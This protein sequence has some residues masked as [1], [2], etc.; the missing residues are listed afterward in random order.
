MKISSENI[1]SKVSELSKSISTYYKEN[2][3]DELCVVVPMNGGV[4]FAVDILREISNPGAD[5]I[6][7]SYVL[8]KDNE[9]IFSGS[10]PN[11]KSHILII[12]DIYDTGETLNELINYLDTEYNPVEIKT[13]VMLD[14]KIEKKSFVDIEWKGFDI[15]DT[16]VYGYG[17]DD[18]NGTMRQVLYITDE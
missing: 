14:K 6:F 1:K 12:E 18:E 7:I 4:P 15:E 8:D 5:K 3:V 16:W 2:H 9:W 13:V 10:K 17:M 11:N